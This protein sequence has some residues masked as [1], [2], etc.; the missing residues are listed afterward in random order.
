LI[1]RLPEENPVRLTLRTLL[2]YLDDTLE[3]SQ[4]KMIG[5]KVAESDAAQEL[6]ARIKQV[7]RR[8]RLTTPPATGPG[9]KIDPNTIAEYLD[10]ELEGDQLAEVEQICLTS[11]VHLAEIAACHQ[12]LTLVLGEPALVPPTSKQ[13]MYAL[14]KGREAIPFRKAAHPGAA[15]EHFEEAQETD[16]ALRLGLPVLRR[17]GGWTH[18]VALAVGG[19]ALAALLA[20]AIYQVLPPAP[21][22]HPNRPDPNRVAAADGAKP[23][24]K[25]TDRTP[26]G[27]DDKGKDDGKMTRADDKA[28]KPQDK[29]D[30][31]GRT[32]RTD[33]KSGKPADKDSASKD[34]SGEKPPPEVAVAAPN[35]GHGIV[36]SYAPPGPPDASI[37]V[38]YRPDKDPADKG[39]WGRLDVRHPDV[40]ANE[41]LVS[42]PGYRSE[43]RTNKG[44]QLML[45]GN[46][47][48]QTSYPA[49][50]GYPQVRESYV[51]IHP[52]D[53]LDLD[54]TLVH[55]RLII[56]NR[57]GGPPARVRVR[58]DN[59]TDPELREVWD[60]TLMDRDGAVALE[61]W[62][63]YPPN[64]SFSRK[65][66]QG[67]DGE[68]YL[69]DLKG[70]VL[71]K[72]E[73]QTY[74]MKAPPE[75]GRM[76]WSS[77]SGATAPAALPTPPEWVSKAPLP[78]PRGVTSQ[79]RSAMMGALE[80]LSISL[81]GKGIDEVLADYRSLKIP[82]DAPKRVLA[83]RCYAAIDDLGNL[84]DCLE[85]ADH[86]EVRMEAF[87]SLR[88][89]SARGYDH[90][91]RLYEAL[92]KKY[93]PGQAEIIVD[94]L[95]ELSQVRQNQPETYD[96]L[97]HYLKH[98]NRAIR[99]LAWIHLHALVPDKALAAVGKKPIFYD[100]AGPA[101]LQENAFREWKKVIPDG[102]LPPRA[103]KPAPPPPPEGTIPPRKP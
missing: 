77:R 63:S 7:T 4:A 53:Q 70:D 47:P 50:P 33:D 22:R 66:Y 37:L 102:K 38:Q 46:V 25:G 28:G 85:D 92:A 57:K 23:A 32:N 81:S 64:I 83:V 54:L 41:S 91:K 1:A 39:Q 35:K 61:L 44:I 80:K 43:V 86:N 62:G 58:F 14:I 97:I 48:E 24:D 71:V 31:T 67:P 96:A 45:W 74:T 94:L 69:F 3:P 51:I 89:W 6:I 100:P 59:P 5:Q 17:K 15:E 99:Q 60:L 11:D 56:T 21:S 20:L 87:H 93:T 98:D 72:R 34:G 76:Y 10:N 88:H 16:E 101:Q 73:G 75:P 103:D 19:V 18:R 79:S 52:H 49:Q 55:G 42:L 68:L 9:A 12:I 95:H 40:V 26:S 2:A 82:E 8:R 13:R 90:D 30:D 65:D 27:A 84:I 29:K 78:L 36:G